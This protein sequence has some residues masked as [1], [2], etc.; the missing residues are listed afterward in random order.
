MTACAFSELAQLLRCAAFS[1][2]AM[3]RPSAKHPAQKVLVDKRPEQNKKKKKLGQADY[4]TGP[5]FKA[6]TN[7][8]YQKGPTWAYVVVC[9]QHLLCCRCTEVLMLQRKDI[10][11]A[12]QRAYV[13]PL[14]KDEGF[15]KPLCEAAMSLLSQWQAAQGVK[16]N[17]TRQWGNRGIQSFCD[18]WPWPT[19]EDD[20]LFPT[21]RTNARRKRMTQDCHKC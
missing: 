20:Y 16:V 10:D 19:G 15:W 1:F 5:A 18:M 9:L 7:H 4:L 12:G 11:L 2:A 6:W 21:R 17:Q 14:K 8:L 3:K 13:K